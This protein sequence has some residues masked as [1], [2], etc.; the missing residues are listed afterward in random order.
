MTGFPGSPR[1]LKGG[2]VLADARTGA[3]G[4]V[5]ALQYNPDTLTRTFQPKAAGSEGA[6]RS[7]ATR[8]KGPPVE[9]IKLEAEIDA[10]DQL[11][12]GDRAALEV[13]VHP[14]LA[15][16]ESLVHPT[17]RQLQSSRALSAGGSLEIAPML[18]PLTLF[19]WSKQRIVPVRLTELNVTEEAFDPD[20]NPIRA[21]VSLGMRV[22]SVDDLGFDNKGGSLYMAYLNNK[23]R[24]AAR[25]AAGSLG[26]LGLT[27][28]P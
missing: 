27:G 9:T 2:I 8:L 7:E 12:T 24:L 5:I 18:A 17:A 21:K 11:E 22:L 19:V 6:D 23:E 16:L 14:Q 13:G 15:V 25:A 4:R 28:L 3:I 10:A 26:P 20:L 1:L